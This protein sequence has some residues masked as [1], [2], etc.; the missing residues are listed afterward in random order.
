[1]NMRMAA[2]VLA[3]LVAFLPGAFGEDVWMQAY[4]YDMPGEGAYYE[5]LTRDYAASGGGVRITLDKWDQAHEQIAQWCAAQEGPDLIVVPDIWL[6]EFAPHIE[7][8]A[9][10]L[11]PDMAGEF[12]DVLYSKALYEGRLLGLVW[13]TST[14]ALFY[15]TGLFEAAGLAPPV[16]QGERRAQ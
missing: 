13:A 5:K 2:V 4:S 15:R 7:D 1:M 9:P 8:L 12:F 11:P 3:G 10:L 6:A 14:K 16:A